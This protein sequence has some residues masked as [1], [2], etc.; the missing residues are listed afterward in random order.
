MLT[1]FKS[2][3]PASTSNNAK[4][5]EERP[6]TSSK[7]SK[8]ADSGGA[9]TDGNT[10]DGQALTSMNSAMYNWLRERG[11]S[12]GDMTHNEIKA[13]REHLANPDTNVRK[14]AMANPAGAPSA[15]ES[16]A[17][18]AV[19]EEERRPPV[20]L[21]VDE[22]GGPSQ[23][24]LDVEEY[25]DLVCQFAMRNSIDQ[26]TDEAQ[27][28]FIVSIMRGMKKTERSDI[29]RYLV[30]QGVARYVGKDNHKSVSFMTDW[31]DFA[32]AVYSDGILKEAKAKAALLNAKMASD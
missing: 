14:R 21:P 20:D 29:V 26:E 16:Q 5:D 3:V 32:A 24:D 27:T 22:H 30:K 25:F 2:D 28:A 12:T 9:A 13:L 18:A 10:S 4:G 6:L 23:N 8:V 7:G 31:E 1:V 19:P 17:K 15:A 11:M